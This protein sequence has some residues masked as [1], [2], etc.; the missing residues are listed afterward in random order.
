MRL[1]SLS[2]YLQ[3]L[4][5]GAQ[6]SQTKLTSQMKA[7]IFFSVFDDI[8]STRTS[9]RTKPRP[10]RAVAAPQMTILNHHFG[11]FW[12][13]KTTPRAAIVPSSI[14]VFVPA[15]PSFLCRLPWMKIMQM[16]MGTRKKKCWQ[17][18]SSPPLNTHT[19]TPRTPHSSSFLLACFGGSVSFGCL[20][21]TL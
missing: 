8:V 5:L 21:S 15:S 10:D 12:P 19:R 6:Q 20:S 13:Q 9:G 3:L 7:I 11:N 1:H 18:L 17:L 14:W 4:N 2:L 16:E